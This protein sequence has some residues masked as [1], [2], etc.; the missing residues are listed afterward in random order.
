MGKVHERIDG[1]LRAFLEAQQVFFVGTAPLSGDGRVNVS[2]KGIDGTFV[3]LDDHTVAYLDLT[4]SGAET[5][6][7]LRENGRITLMFCAF[8]G[9]PNIVRLHGRGRVVSLYDAE[10]A[11]LAGHF[12]ERRGARAVIVVDVERVSDSCGYGIPLYDHV[13]E[14][15]LLPEFMDRKGLDGQ[16]TYRRAKNRTSIDGLPAFDDD[17]LPV[18]AGVDPQG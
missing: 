18:E 3:V 12:G 11:D 14:R 15:D 6:A 10:F 16:A 9:P 1:R 13:G 8:D 7:H 4:A 17:P 2:P 5:I